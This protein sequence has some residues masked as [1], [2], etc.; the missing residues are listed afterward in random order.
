MQLITVIP[1]WLYL[2]F[3]PSG[4]HLSMVSSWI[5]QA[6]RAIPPFVISGVIS[7]F[8]ILR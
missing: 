8:H 7:S 3:H 1:Q 2:A 6:T 4:F 5:R